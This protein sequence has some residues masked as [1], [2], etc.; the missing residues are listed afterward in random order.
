MKYRIPALI[1]VLLSCLGLTAIFLGYRVIGQSLIVVAYAASFAS[2]KT[3]G[4]TVSALVLILAGGS[5]AGIYYS[6]GV[7]PLLSIA[8]VLATFQNIFLELF[9]RSAIYNDI[10]FK[11]ITGI[12][13]IA[14]YIT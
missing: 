7:F 14:C 9:F 5:M 1:S 6:P 11:I 2:F 13:S 10:K 4:G 8:L 3:N 12:L